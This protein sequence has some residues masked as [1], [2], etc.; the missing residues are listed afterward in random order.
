MEELNESNFALSAILK[1]TFD[2]CVFTQ[3]T[4]CLSYLLRYM[5]ANRYQK[6]RLMNVLLGTTCGKIIAAFS[7]P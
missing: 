2:R 5:K 6:R 3:P 7:I 4:L 1:T